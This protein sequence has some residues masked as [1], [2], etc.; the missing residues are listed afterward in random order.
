MQHG[1]SPLAPVSGSPCYVLNPLPLLAVGPAVAGPAGRAA[2][3]RGG[4][5]AAGLLAGGR[6][7]PAVLRPPL[8][9]PAAVS[10]ARRSVLQQWASSSLH[11]VSCSGGKFTARFALD[12]VACTPSAGC[13]AARCTASGPKAWLVGTSGAVPFYGN[14]HPPRPSGPAAPHPTPPFLQVLQHARVAGLCGPAAALGLPE[15][16]AS[17]A[18]LPQPPRR[19]LPQHRR[20]WLGRAHV[21]GRRRRRQPSGGLWHCLVRVP[22]MQPQLSAAGAVAAAG[23]CCGWDLLAR[24]A[25]LVPIALPSCSYMLSTRLTLGLI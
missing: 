24:G 22:H 4:G 15:L 19:H 18:C 20:H 12:A 17:H 21:H 8:C 9:R 3:W 13:S 2:A 10:V 7:G 25:A 11:N 1:S 6:L 5:A 23:E 14:G 16:A